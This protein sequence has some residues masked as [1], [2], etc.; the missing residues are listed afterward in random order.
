MIT[1]VM[2][3]RQVLPHGKPDRDKIGMG[4]AGNWTDVMSYVKYA[5]SAVYVQVKTRL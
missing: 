4:L 5:I 3:L 2:C 1:F